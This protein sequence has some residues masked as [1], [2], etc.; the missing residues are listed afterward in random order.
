MTVRQQTVAINDD[1]EWVREG[2]D[3]L[4]VL[5]DEEVKRT[6]RARRPSC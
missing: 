3:G 5:D 2:I 4:P 1:L 6:A